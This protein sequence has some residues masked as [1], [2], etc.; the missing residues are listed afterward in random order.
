MLT[1]ILVIL[2]VFLIIIVG[3]CAIGE[4]LNMDI[5]PYL[6]AVAVENNFLFGRGVT[7]GLLHGC[8]R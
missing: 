7:D 2:T 6:M 8:C 5:V 1:D 3:V 4:K